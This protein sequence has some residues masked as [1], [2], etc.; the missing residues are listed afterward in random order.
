VN[1]ALTTDS[2]QRKTLPIATGV[3]DYFPAALAAV[4]ALS[5]SGNDKHNPGEPL[6]HARGKSSDHADCIVRHLIDRGTIGDDGVRHSTSVAWRALALLQ[7]ELEREEG[8]PLPRGAKAAEPEPVTKW[9]GLQTFLK[10]IASA[11]KPAEPEHPLLHL[12]T[13]TT[14]PTIRTVFKCS[15]PACDSTEVWGGDLAHWEIREAIRVG[16]FERIPCDNPDC[17]GH[18]VFA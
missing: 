17:S 11:P 3:L 14:P 15:N 16:A 1:L 12:D 18:L 9:A 6:H 4:A 2:A 7:E 8:A 10:D 5:K 13:T